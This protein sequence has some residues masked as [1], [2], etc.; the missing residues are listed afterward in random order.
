VGRDAI[1]LSGDLR[2][3]NKGRL[4]VDTNT[5]HLQ[6]TAARLLLKIIPSKTASHIFQLMYLQVQLC[7]LP[8]EVCSAHL[9]A[10][11]ATWNR[12]FLGELAYTIW[13]KAVWLAPYSFS[14]MLVRASGTKHCLK[15]Y[16]VS[17]CGHT[18]SARF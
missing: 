8:C 4:L 9:T 13:T 14:P 10:L 18:I 16:L 11:Q 17:L 15:C 6:C 3:L 1:N 12:A 7:G 5:E 2:R